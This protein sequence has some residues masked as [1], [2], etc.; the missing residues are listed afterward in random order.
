MESGI[1]R[2]E[3]TNAVFI[4]PVRVLNRSYNKFKVSP[5][6]YYSRLF[7]SKQSAKESSKSRKRKRKGKDKKAHALNERER[8][9]DQRHQ[10]ITER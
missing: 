4:D 3:D 10:V 8:A 2:F 7:E 1:Y 6:A 9:A 5:S